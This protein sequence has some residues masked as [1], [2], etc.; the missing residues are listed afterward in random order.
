VSPTATTGTVT[1]YD[2][3]TSLGKATLS[4]G[5]ATLSTKFA[6]GTHSVTAT[7]D[8]DSTF[9]SS[10]SSAV[11]IVSTAALSSVRYTTI[12]VDASSTTLAAGESVM[13]T[14]TLS[15]SEATGKVRFYDA[16]TSPVSLLGTATLDSGT[17][18]LPVTFTNTGTHQIM[19]SYIGPSEYAVSTTQDALPIITDK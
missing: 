14:A 13:L 3:S 2:G 16:S 19:A 15:D 12:T 9:A 11:S 18:T 5:A 6:A 7:Y 10:T 17:A 4:A 1:F 8:G